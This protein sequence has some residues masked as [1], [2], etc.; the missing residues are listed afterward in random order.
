MWG[1]KYIIQKVLWKRSRKIRTEL[2]VIGLCCTLRTAPASCRLVMNTRKTI[3]FL[4]F[5]NQKISKNL[6][7]E[8]STS[9]YLFCKKTSS[10]VARVLTRPERTPE[11]GPSQ[12]TW[13]IYRKPFWI[14]IYQTHK[15]TLNFSWKVLHFYYWFLKCLRFSFVI[16]NFRNL[17]PVRLKVK[18]KIS[19]SG[20]RP[21]ILDSGPLWVGASFLEVSV[22]FKKCDLFL[23][24]IHEGVRFI[25]SK[26]DY[27]HKLM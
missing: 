10:E 26:N 11:I 23:N 24:L 20:L 18:R 5:R 1:M 27:D 9:F 25:F 8:Y 16:S 22:S 17:K 7:I 21:G 19:T 12:R 6:T 2:A 15:K 14:L 4:N 3:D 13:Q